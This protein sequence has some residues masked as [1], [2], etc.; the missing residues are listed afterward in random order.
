MFYQYI[1]LALTL[2]ALT[3]CAMVCTLITTDN[4]K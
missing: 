1:M 3:V 4:P 2:Y